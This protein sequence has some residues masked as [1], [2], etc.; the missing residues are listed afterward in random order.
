MSD[1]TQPLPL[2]T[3]N[4]P[5]NMKLAERPPVVIMDT[6]PAAPKA[7]K[8]VEDLFNYRPS[9]SVRD[10]KHKQID[11]FADAL[12]AMIV[13]L[14]SKLAKEKDPNP[15]YGFVPDVSIYHAEVNKN[16]VNFARVVDATVADSADKT[17]AIRNIRL[18]RILL[19]ECIIAKARGNL[20]AS[21]THN[22]IRDLL[23]DAR[24]W[25]NDT[26]ALTE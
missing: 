17:I 5:T 26:L 8:T 18:A 15:K 14:L 1:P 19:H 25:A 9:S 23:N 16:V 4:L 10:L 7:V 24:R 11:D 21:G 3:S 22:R 12:E 2:P 6:T 20:V 13:D